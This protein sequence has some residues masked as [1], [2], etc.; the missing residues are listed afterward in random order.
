MRPIRTVRGLVLPLYQPDIDT[1]QIMPKQFLAR[2]SKT[3]YGKHVF[4]EW[5]QD[6][7]F[8]FNDRRFA[9]AH[10][11]VTGRNFGSGSSREHAVWGLQQYGIEAVLAPSFS[12]IFVGNCVQNGLLPASIPNGVAAQIAASALVDPTAIIDVDLV[13]RRVRGHGSTWNS[14]S[15]TKTGR[16]FCSVATISA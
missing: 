12:D 1:D 14:L 3:G 15:Q 4:H 8:V 13:D 10:I 11:L 5:R 2:T 7:R 6:P 9:G 16:V